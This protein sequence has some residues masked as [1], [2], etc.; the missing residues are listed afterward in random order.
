MENNSDR[1][2]GKAG[3]YDAYR[4]D[5]PSR[6]IDYVIDR[7]V[8]TERDTVADI[9][10]GT[11]KFARLLLERDIPVTAVEPNR[12]MR[13]LGEKTLGEFPGFVSVNAT[14][15]DT[16][17][18]SGRIALVVAAQSF[19][20]FDPDK[21]RLECRRILKP[22]R[23]V[24]LVWNCRDERNRMVMEWRDLCVRHCPDFQG[25]SV[26]SSCPSGFFRDEKA[27]HRE[28][29]FRITCDLDA[30]LGRNRSS[31]YAPNMEDPSYAAFEK[32]LTSLFRRYSKKG[33]L[34]I[35][36]VARSYL[37]KV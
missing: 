7:N 12:D 9:G 30:F 3:D 1:F 15:E 23:N 22:S 34:T 14:A 2:T 29:R 6:L 31:S 26:K 35:P 32:D 28:F 10:A 4:P 19:Q 21:F 5:Y 8:L 33:L 25:F 37:G 16:G 20:W 27:E 36:M 11:G 18:R 17:I 13:E 24:L